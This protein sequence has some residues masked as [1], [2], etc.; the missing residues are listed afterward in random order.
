MSDEIQNVETPKA[1][2]SGP[3]K[4]SKKAAMKSFLN[5]LFFAHSDYNFERLQGIGFLLSMSPI[6]DELYDKDDIKGRKEAMMRHTP[7]FNTEPRIGCMIVGLCAAMEERIASGEKELAGDAMGGIK[8]GL[9]GPLAGIGDTL[10]Q[11][12]L[13]PLLLSMVIGLSMVG[14]LTGPVLYIVL[15]ISLVCIIGYYCFML[16]YKKGDE[17]IVNFIESGVIN[18]VIKGASVMGCLVMGA[19]VANFVRL[20]TA[21][22]FKITTGEFDLQKNFFDP[23]MPRILPLILTLLVFKLLQHE[24]MNS[25]KAMIVLVA[26]GIVLGL[27]RIV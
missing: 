23:I 15:F 25:L 1:A 3:K 4:V 22:K 18:K 6:I 10:F 17:A 16:G 7:F 21:V 27:L 14:N 26:A 5:W 19:L 11:G 24:K 2:A 13:A 20:S 9:M 8:Y 12:I